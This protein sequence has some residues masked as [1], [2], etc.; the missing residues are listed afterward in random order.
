MNEFQQIIRDRSR[1]T[2]CRIDIEYVRAHLNHLKG[3]LHER[4]AVESRLNVLSYQQYVEQIAVDW[5]DDLHMGCAVVLNNDAT[6][7]PVGVALA[8]IKAYRDDVRRPMELNWPKTN[9]YRQNEGAVVLG[10]PGPRQTTSRPIGCWLFC[11]GW[12][13]ITLF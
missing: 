13:V 7:A 8:N 9:A 12:T 11:I 4:D 6:Q 2:I 1:Y 10:V 3:L 5:R